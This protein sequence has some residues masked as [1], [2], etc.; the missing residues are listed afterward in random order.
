MQYQPKIL[1]A[2]G[3]FTPSD[4]REGYTAFFRIQTQFNSADTTICY[5]IKKGRSLYQ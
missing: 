3:F 4:S 1:P 5:E 2:N